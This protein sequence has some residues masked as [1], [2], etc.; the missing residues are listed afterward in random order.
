MMMMVLSQEEIDSLLSTISTTPAPA[1]VAQGS[2]EGGAVIFQE[3]PSQVN[4]GE[5]P[6]HPRFWKW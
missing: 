1:P 2:S 3:D 5:E 6:H 4:G